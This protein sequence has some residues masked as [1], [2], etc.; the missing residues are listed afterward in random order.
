[1]IIEST[2]WNYLIWISQ[3]EVIIPYPVMLD[4]NKT[5]KGT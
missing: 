2:H 3:S 5:I 4:L 1:M